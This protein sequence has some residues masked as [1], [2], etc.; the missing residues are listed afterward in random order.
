MSVDFT[1]F[2]KRTVV[3]LLADAIESDLARIG[4]GALAPSGRVLSE[5]HG[6]SLMT[7]QKALALL[8]SRK[9][10]VSRGARRRLAV[11]QEIQVARAA[12]SVRRLLVVSNDS[13]VSYDTSIALG[14]ERMERLLR[15]R[16]DGFR[17]ID[18][19]TLPEEARVAAV[20]RALKDFLP[21]HCVLMRPDPR[22][23]A[24]VRGAGRK[25]ATM[26][27]RLPMRGV[28]TLGVM[29][30]YLMDI[31]LPKLAALGHRKA[32]MPF[33]GRVKKLRRSTREIA[34]SAR[35]HGV[36]VDLHF[37]H[38]PCTPD[39]MAR[40]LEHGLNG[41]ATAVIFPQWTDFV[42]AISPLSAMGLRM[43]SDLSVVSL[44]CNFSARMY[45]PPVA[46]CISSPDS[47][48]SQT[49]LWI[50]SAKVDD[51][52]YSRVYERTWDSGGTIGPAPAVL[53]LERIRRSGSTAP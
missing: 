17:F 11:S 8:V 24:C 18:L 44:V 14:V 25:V 43:P 33:L 28:S 12:A 27:S 7:V 39:N 37:T 19:S 30:G 40:A 9:V 20:R 51:A 42:A 23:Y 35:R 47:I 34:R 5:T 4:P 6:V 2:Q 41:G 32:F 15:D 26:F 48:A 21:T 36:Q 45:S 52:V 22:T 31:A 16:G 13:L 50:D 49:L 38:V 1:M 3:Q 10:L 29:Y 53:P 46:G